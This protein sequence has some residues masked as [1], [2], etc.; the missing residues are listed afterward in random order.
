MAKPMSRRV[1]LGIVEG[2]LRESRDWG[3][4]G[5]DEDFDA[6][7]AESI[8]NAIDG[9]GALEQGPM[10]D[11]EVAALAAEIGNLC[12]RFA[13]EW[14]ELVSARSGLS[15]E[16]RVNES[17]EDK[18]I[19]ASHAQQFRAVLDRYALAIQHSEPEVTGG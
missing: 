16:D 7:V 4:A 17:A 14:D 5:P 11:A 9:P 10:T 3:R 1:K 15:A 12:E 6:L 19:E 13:R 2:V 18:R 8:V